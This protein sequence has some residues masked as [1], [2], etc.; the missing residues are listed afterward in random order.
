MSPEG[1]QDALAEALDWERA[2]MA[3]E[4][5]EGL[6]QG[7]CGISLQLNALE[8]RIRAQAPGLAEDL[9]ELRKSV[10]QNIEESRALFRTLRPPIDG[11]TSLL[12]ALRGLAQADLGG[13]NVEVTT[14]L[15]AP[16]IEKS[17][18]VALYR[19]AQAAL[20]EAKAHPGV[21]NVRIDLGLIGGSVRLRFSDDRPDPS[22]RSSAALRIMAAEARR[23]RVLFSFH[24]SLAAEWPLEC[25]AAPQ[26]AQSSIAAQAPAAGKQAC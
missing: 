18:A 11:G 15:A 7:L 21:G 3:E 23:G 19:V 8:R 13:G 25:V 1:E 22:D 6:C 14:M 5:H 24:A 26:P 17:A 12:T 2:A 10:D 4:L 16:D 20:R 9:E